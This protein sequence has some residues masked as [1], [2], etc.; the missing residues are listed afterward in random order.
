[1]SMDFNLEIA[2]VQSRIAEIYGAGQA[3][4]DAAPS[5]PGANRGNFAALV[6]QQLAAAQPSSSTGQPPAPGAIDQLVQANASAQQVDPDLIRAVIANESAFDPNATSRTGAQGLMQLE[7][8]TAASLGVEN[9]YDPAQ[10]IAGGTRYLRGLL[11]RFGGDLRLAVAAYNAGPGAV[12]EHGGVPP[13]A[14]TQNY[15]RNV[16]DTYQ[17]YKDR[18]S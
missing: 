10:N 11:D 12:E 9:A 14:E 4:D 2:R 6:N 18:P 17:Q 13:Y 5:G 8:D 7:P 1:M 15:V 16:L 3:N